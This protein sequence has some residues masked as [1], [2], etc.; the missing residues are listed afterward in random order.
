MVGTS[1]TE[2]ESNITAGSTALLLKSRATSV[3]TKVS[4]ALEA[5][6][7]KTCKKAVTTEGDNRKNVF[8]NLTQG[9]LIECRKSKKVSSQCL[10]L[11]YCDA[12]ASLPAYTVASLC[13]RN[14]L[15]LRA[16]KENESAVNMVS[17]PLCLPAREVLP[18]FREC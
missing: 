14:S 9:H 11:K 12:C 4:D 1:V 6:S 16:L 3:V 18:Y 13:F 15:L 8:H 5:I 17:S 10:V 7:C 2:S